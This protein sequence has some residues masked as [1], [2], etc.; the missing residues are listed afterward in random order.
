MIVERRVPVPQEHGIDKRLLF[1]RQIQIVREVPD[2]ILSGIWSVR[3]E[4]ISSAPGLEKDN[5]LL[6]LELSGC[7]LREEMGRTVL[8]CDK[9]CV[10][11]VVCVAEGADQAVELARFPDAQLYS[12]LSSWRSP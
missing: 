8:S 12:P 11:N 6:E 3:G 7:S 5:R 4:R 9:L 10:S 1:Q 2:V